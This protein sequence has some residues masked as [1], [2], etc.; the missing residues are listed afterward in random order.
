[1]NCSF[2]ESFEYPFTLSVNIFQRCYH[3][4]PHIS[5]NVGLVI[6]SWFISGTSTHG[7]H[8]TVLYPQGFHGQYDGHAQSNS[9]VLRQCVSA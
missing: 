9:Q 1:M 8:L 7:T 4:S 6:A 3:P 2:C 5:I